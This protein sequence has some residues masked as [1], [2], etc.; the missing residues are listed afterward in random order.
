MKSVL[1]PSQSVPSKT[2]ALSLMLPSGSDPSRADLMARWYLSIKDRWITN[3]P[4]DE[5][6]ESTAKMMKKSRK[7]HKCLS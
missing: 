2:V 5:I 1:N 4:E 6:L 7:N 3:E